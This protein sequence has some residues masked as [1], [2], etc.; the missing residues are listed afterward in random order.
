MKIQADFSLD[1]VWE[2]IWNNIKTGIETNNPFYKTPAFISLRKNYPVGRVVVLRELDKDMQ[3]WFYTDSRSEKVKY[4]ERMPVGNFLFYDQELQLQVRIM[5]K[6]S[7]H[8]EDD[9]ANEIWAQMPARNRKDYGGE[10]APGI[11]IENP[12]AQSHDGKLGYHFCA[13][14]CSPFEVEILQLNPEGHLRAK[15]EKSTAGWTQQWIAS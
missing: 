13:I 10:F 3:F 2:T 12:E 5:V 4:L 11:H 6:V 7:L 9:I 1:R 14:C 8:K 15:Y